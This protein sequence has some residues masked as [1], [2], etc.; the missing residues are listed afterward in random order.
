MKKCSDCKFGKN[1]GCGFKK[2]WERKFLYTTN[3]K[4]YTHC[5]KHVLIKAK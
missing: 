1:A 2:Y 3:S 5:D 4:T